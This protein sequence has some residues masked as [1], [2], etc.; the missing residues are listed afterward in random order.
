MKAL[1]YC[2]CSV[3]YLIS[4][5]IFCKINLVQRLQMWV[6]TWWWLDCDTRLNMGFEVKPL[7]SQWFG[8]SVF[9]WNA[10]YRK[11]LHHHSWV[12]HSDYRNACT[13]LKQCTAHKV[14]N[15][16]RKL[17]YKFRFLGYFRL[18]SYILSTTW[19]I[20]SALLNL[21]IKICYR[22]VVI[23]IAWVIEI[24]TAPGHFE[25]CHHQLIMW[26]IMWIM[27]FD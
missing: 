7:E 12:L 13:Y 27:C 5:K 11:N 10:E 22:F 26:R 9:G 18:S 4:L 19:N 24:H 23:W 17:N 8:W 21:I 6:V 14:E 15:V 3:F 20:I 2:Y 1:Y 16:L 25:V